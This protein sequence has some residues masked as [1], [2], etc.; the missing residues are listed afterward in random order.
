MIRN[1]VRLTMLRANTASGTF[2][3]GTTRLEN[4]TCWQ[5]GKR[6]KVCLPR[7]QIVEGFLFNTLQGNCW[8]KWSKPGNR[9]TDCC[10][11]SPHPLWPESN[12]RRIVGMPVKPEFNHNVS[13]LLASTVCSTSTNNLN[14]DTKEEQSHLSRFSWKEEFKIQKA[15]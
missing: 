3:P 11:L 5:R 15:H 1:T 4:V 7:M 2:W 6:D 14:G 13:D 12:S 9:C 10:S 8:S